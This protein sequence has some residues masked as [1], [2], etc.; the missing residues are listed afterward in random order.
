MWLQIKIGRIRRRQQSKYLDHWPQGS[1][2]SRFSSHL[3]S[4]KKLIDDGIRVGSFR[5]DVCLLLKGIG[6]RI[7][8]TSQYVQVFS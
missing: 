4:C 7:K 2:T 1:F 6:E 5:A 3:H 8:S